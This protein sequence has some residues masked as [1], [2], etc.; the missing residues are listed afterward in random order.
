M[1][2]VVPEHIYKLQPYLPGKPAEQVE[3]ET[4]VPRAIKLASNE[5]PFGPSPRVQEAVAAAIGQLHRYPDVHVQALRDRLATKWGVKPSMFVFGNGSN[6]LIDVVLHTFATPGSGDQ[7]IIGDPSYAYYQLRFTV[8]NVDTVLVPLRQNLYWSCDDLLA[9]ITPKTRLMML[10]NPNNPTGAHL[11]GSEVLR[12]VRSVPESVTLVMDEAYIEYC[13]QHCPTAIPLLAQREN[14]VVLRTFSKAYGLA[15]LGVGYAVTSPRLAQYMERVRR[16]FSVSTVAQA[17]AIAA[18]EDEAHL[19]EIVRI[20]LAERSRVGE[21]LRT[22]G[23]TVVPSQANFLLFGP[24]PERKVA[25][26]RKPVAASHLVAAL[27]QRGIIIREMK[28]PI[29]DYVRVSIGTPEENTAF[30]D[31]LTAI[32]REEAPSVARP[33]PVQLAAP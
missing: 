2:S 13:D 11:S 8:A 33:V 14:M 16:A 25:K 24:I 29:S 17:A 27:L 1:T 5:N 28:A 19:A 9:A 18:V 20:N 4:G 6:E 30:L 22:M 10:A 12:L 7:V 3:R 32:D 15:G 26:G 31:A 23:Y 21:A